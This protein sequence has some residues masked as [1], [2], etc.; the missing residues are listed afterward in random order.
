MPDVEEHY[1]EHA[2]RKRQQ[3]PHVVYEISG[4]LHAIH[5]RRI[6]NEVL[7]LI[8]YPSG[9]DAGIQFS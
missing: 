1:S 7:Q 5:S 6:L 3:S 4:F 2:T 8:A 9:L